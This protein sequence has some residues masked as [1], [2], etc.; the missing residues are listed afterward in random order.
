MKSIFRFRWL[1]EV[2]DVALRHL[3][4][5]GAD[6]IPCAGYRVP[7]VRPKASQRDKFYL[8]WQLEE[9]SLLTSAP[10]LQTR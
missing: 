2:G 10:T 3:S 8:G 7:P 9:V 6:V 1:S 5:R 4:P